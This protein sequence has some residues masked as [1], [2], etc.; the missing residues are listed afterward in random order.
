VQDSIGLEISS[1]GRRVIGADINVLDDKATD[2][3]LYGL[4]TALKLTS[5]NIG[6]RLEE[7]AFVAGEPKNWV[8]TRS[9]PTNIV[10]KHTNPEDAVAM[11]IRL[12]AS[13]GKA[14]LVYN[15]QIR[16][17]SNIL[18]STG[19]GKVFTGVVPY[20]YVIHQREGF[21]RIR[22]GSDVADA[23]LF[24][25]NGSVDVSAFIVNRLGKYEGPI[26]AQ[27]ETLK[28]EPGYV[29]FTQA[30]YEAN[31]SDGFVNV[32]LRRFDGMAGEAI[33]DCDSAQST[34][35]GG[36]SV[37]ALGVDYENYNVTHTW[38]DQDM[39]DQTFKINFNVDTVNEAPFEMFFLFLNADPASD[40]SMGNNWFC[41]VKILEGESD[42][43]GGT[44][45]E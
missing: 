27:P 33:F 26:F 20:A 40:A 29:E 6:F 13:T 15:R 41:K 7:G 43:P 1:W 9:A 8:D 4:A 19:I 17:N 39:A 37:P 24:K 36:P 42:E 38:N 10:G 11:K 16:R 30:V 22:L 5:P 3:E 45:A 34:A 32:T 2:T 35:H 23:D 12:D 31:E 18:L 14:F 28:V 21:A 44:S 25:N